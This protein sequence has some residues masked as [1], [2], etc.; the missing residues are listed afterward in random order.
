MQAQRSPEKSKFNRPSSTPAKRASWFKAAAQRTPRCDPFVWSCIDHLVQCSCSACHH[1][2]K[3]QLV[4]SSRASLFA[5]VALMTGYSTSMAVVMNRAGPSL[6]AAVHNLTLPFRR[7]LLA[8]PVLSCPPLAVAKFLVARRFIW[9]CIAALAAVHLQAPASCLACAALL[10]L[11][12]PRSHRPDRAQRGA[13]CHR[14]LSSM[15]HC[16]CRPHVQWSRHVETQKPMR[17]MWMTRDDSATLLRRM[18]A[19]QPPDET[20]KHVPEEES[21]RT[22]HTIRRSQVCGA[23]RLVALRLVWGAES[24]DC[25]EVL[26]WVCMHSKKKENI[27]KIMIKK[28]KVFY[29]V[30]CNVIGYSGKKRKIGFK[31][32]CFFF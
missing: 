5:S 16:G 30:N 15:R 9:T 32:Y 12:L 14:S 19:T 1:Q 24:C 3:R 6:R 28:K 27:R 23:V 31:K 8:S 4:A 7:T 20:S 21:V 26:Q 2:D 25:G 22:A 18:D 13:R 11:H 10:L 17:A 29:T